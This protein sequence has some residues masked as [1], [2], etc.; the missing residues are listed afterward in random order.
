MVRLTILYQIPEFTSPEH[1]AA[2]QKHWGKITEMVDDGKTNGR[3][4]MKQVSKTTY[5]ITR[6]FIDRESANEFLAFVNANLQ[7]KPHLDAV[8]EDVTP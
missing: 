8:I 1:I 7:P 5:T 4:V 6:E 2:S 3:R